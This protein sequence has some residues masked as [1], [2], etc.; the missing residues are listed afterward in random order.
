MPSVATGGSREAVHGFR[1]THGHDPGSP[2]ITGRALLP[3]SG[4]LSG[5]MS[6][7]CNRPVTLGAYSGRKGG[8]PDTGTAAMI[9]Y[10]NSYRFDYFCGWRYLVSPAFREM[11]R[12]KWGRTPVTRLLCYAGVLFSLLVTTGAGVLAM[13]AGWYLMHG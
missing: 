8:C 1:A 4:P 3:G 2:P 9:N 11:L 13:L 7:F 6:W 12:A 10:S 5:V